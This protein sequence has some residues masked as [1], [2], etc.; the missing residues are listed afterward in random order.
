MDTRSTDN[1]EMARAKGLVDHWKRWSK[2]RANFVWFYVWSMRKLLPINLQFATKNF[3][4][5]GLEDQSQKERKRERLY[6]IKR[7]WSCKKSLQLTWTEK[8]VTRSSIDLRAVNKM[9]LYI[10]RDLK[11]RKLDTRIC[12]NTGV[13][14]E[15]WVGPSVLNVSV[16]TSCTRARTRR[17]T[18][19]FRVDRTRG[20]LKEQKE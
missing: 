1:C 19:R 17:P 12:L 15:G 8:S 10:M 7:R 3:K 6:K 20:A 14:G 13:D 2:T 9:I 4:R 11:N 16:S 5:L 18:E